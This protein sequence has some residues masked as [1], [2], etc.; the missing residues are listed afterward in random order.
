M[1]Y[2]IERYKTNIKM[3][4]YYRLKVHEAV[5]ENADDD[6]EMYSELAGACY[7]RAY[8]YYKILV[9]DFDIELSSMVKARKE[10]EKAGGDKYYTEV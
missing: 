6:V 1:E 3:G 10:A 5:N 8:A 4:T 9:A 2:L 7:D